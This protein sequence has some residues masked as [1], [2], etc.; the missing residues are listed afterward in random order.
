MLTST[1]SRSPAFS[2]FGDPHQTRVERAI[3]EFRSGRPVLFSGGVRSVL[4]MPTEAVDGPAGDMMLEWAVRGAYLVLTRPRLHHLGV[5]NGVGPRRFPLP[6]LDRNLIDRLS[7]QTDAAMTDAAMTDTGES[8]SPV[9]EAALELAQ[10]AYLI[11]SVIAVEAQ[12]PA[13]LVEAGALEVEATA[14]F[15]FRDIAARQMRIV[16]RSPVP[17]AEARDSEFVVFRGGEGMR[18]QVAIV[19]GDPDLSKP[20]LTRVHSA[21]LTGDLFGSLKCDCGD[22]LRGGVKR[23]AESGGGIML[24]LDQEGRGSGIANKMRAYKLQCDGL[25]TYQADSVL[26]LDLD[27][28]HFAMAGTMLRLLGV[29]RV[30]LLTNNPEKIA[31]L[32]A[33][34]I[35]VVQDLRMFGRPTEENVRYLQAKRDRAGHR[36]GIEA[37][38]GEPAA[39]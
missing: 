26:G 22:Q 39:E 5:A 7:R 28:R 15:N 9:E 38:F 18:D 1:P 2:L 10:L 37:L 17:L 12:D 25:D 19:V 16:S 33:A 27:S 13:R 14:I 36:I 20:V 34:G 21:C 23:M 24:Y 29:A 8:V 35:D 11:P 32:K 6:M 4:A 3:A 30:H 31:A